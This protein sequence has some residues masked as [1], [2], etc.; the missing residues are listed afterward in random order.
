MPGARAA[1]RA[2]SA[3]AADPVRRAELKKLF[4]LLRRQTGHDMSQYKTDNLSFGIDHRMAVHQSTDLESY[5]RH[6]QRDPSE[7]EALFRNLLIGVTRFFRDPEAFTAFG[8][9]A[10]GALCARKSP[11]GTLRAWVPGCSSGEE[12]YT[13]AIILRERMGGGQPFKVRVFGTDIDSRALDRARPGRYSAA[14]AP[15]VSPERLSSCFSLDPE[16]GGYRIGN[17]IRKLVRFSEHDL[18]RPPPFYALDLISCRNV[19]IYMRAELQN[20]ILAR[21]HQALNPGGVLLLGTSENVGDRSDL[22]VPL[23][24]ISRIYRRVSTNESRQVVPGI[25]DPGAG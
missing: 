19:L 20:K 6:L 8:E 18:V 12:A 15:D 22:F 9:E 13:V 4:I 24:R 7:V 10:V 14:I 2:S 23:N 16:G 25:P 3:A 5:V 11:G 21:F 17:E 1:G